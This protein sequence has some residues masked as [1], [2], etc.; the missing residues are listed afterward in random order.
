M[1]KGY[2][3]GGS[4][5]ASLNFNVK[6]YTSEVELK[7]DKPR[8]NTIGVITT[9]TMTSW[10]FSATEPTEPEVGMVWIFVGKESSV[11]FNALKKH[12]LQVYPRKAKQYVGGTFEDKPVYSYQNGEWVTVWNG[13]LYE[14]GNKFEFIT[15]GWAFVHGRVPDTYNIGTYTDNKDSITLTVTKDKA[16]I[17]AVTEKKIDLTEHKTL[18]INI[19]NENVGYLWL[20]V[21][22]TQVMSSGVARTDNL[23]A[24]K[25]SLDISALDGEY[26]VAVEAFSNKESTGAGSATFDEVWLSEV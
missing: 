8:E 5:G 11:E 17:E 13:E 16:T 2:K 14:K 3:H 12:T 24:G 1:G 19:T 4:G 10:V 20:K 23:T 18:N 25:G 9:T 15:G 22:T 6:T 21:G 26:Y 7:A